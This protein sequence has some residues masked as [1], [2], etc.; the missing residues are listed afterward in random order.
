MDIEKKKLLH[1]VDHTLL[2][3]FATTEEIQNLCDEASRAKVFSVCISPSYV[4]LA[5]KLLLGSKVK[6]CTVVGFPNGYSTTKTKLFET[7]D[8]LTNGADEIDMVINLGFVKNKEYNKLLKEITEIK[9]ICK[10][11]VLKV[12][13]ENCYLTTEEKIDMCKI[14]T[15]SGANY[16]KTSTGFGAGGATFE[17]VRLIKKHIGK[18]VK[19]KAA[20]GVSSFEIAQSFL[21]LG[22]SRIG[23][24]KLAK[25][26]IN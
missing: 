23:S 11:N 10:N 8:A 16:I 15:D 25:L 18:D 21:E 19:I 5:K 13:T 2:T 4:T 9:K 3:A 26:A 20:G 7:E 22:V 17:D 14:V 1:I 24:S 6:V 12:I